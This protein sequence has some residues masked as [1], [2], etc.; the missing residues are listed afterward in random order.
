LYVFIF[1]EECGSICDITPN[2]DE[3]YETY[4]CDLHGE[5]NGVESDKWLCIG[6]ESFEPYVSRKKIRA[7]RIKYGWL[8]NEINGVC[9]AYPWMPF[10]MFKRKHKCLHFEV[11]D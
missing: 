11:R 3:G 1:C 7:I 2:Y 5:V 4:K 8:S 6:C 10:K 9:D